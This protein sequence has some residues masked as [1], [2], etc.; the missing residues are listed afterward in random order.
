MGCAIHEHGGGG[1]V[2][3]PGQCDPPSPTIDAEVGRGAL[4]GDVVRVHHGYGEHHGILVMVVMGTVTVSNFPIL[5]TLCTLTRSVW[6]YHGVRVAQVQLG[7]AGE[8]EGHGQGGDTKK[9]AVVA[10]RR[11]RGW[12]GDGG[13]GSTETVAAAAQRWQRQQHRDGSGGGGTELAAAVARR[14]WQ[15]W[16]G[17]GGG[18]GM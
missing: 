13:G 4:R 8:H 6:V 15:R 1:V 11:Q 17:E 14:G 7:R 18:S 3:W 5:C 10:G 12:Y 16:H 2:I 9:V